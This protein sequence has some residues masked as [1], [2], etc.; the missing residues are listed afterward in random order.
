M[1]SSSLVVGVTSSCPAGNYDY[2]QF[3]DSTFSAFLLYSRFKIEY[4][5]SSLKRLFNTLSFCRFD[6]ISAIIFLS[7]LS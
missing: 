5:H 2:C 4:A 6:N 1:D 7:Y 3:S